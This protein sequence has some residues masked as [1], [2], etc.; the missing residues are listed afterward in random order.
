[1][2]IQKTEKYFIITF[3]YS[4]HLVDAVKN[5]PN[6]MWDNANKCWKV[7]NNYESE[8]MSFSKTYGFRFENT[9]K[10]VVEE[11]IL[12]IPPMP[13]LGHALD[14]QI[15]P[16]PYQKQGIAFGLQ[17]KRF[18]N[19]DK[20]GLGKT[21]QA[22]ATVHTANAYPCL[23]ICPSTLKENWKREFKKF[24]G[25]DRAM[26]LNED[27]KRNYPSFYSAGICNAYITN[28]E[29][30]KKY[31]VDDL[32]NG[33]K[34]LTMKHI[35]FK[36]EIQMFKSIIIDESHRCKNGKAQQTKFCMGISQGK[37]YVI[38]LSGTPVIN[39]PK[40]LIS[41]LHIMGRLG[42][43]GGYKKFV[44][45]YC[46][47]YNGAS[48]LRELNS[49]LA[50]TCF[51]QR[52]K[53]DVLKDLPAKVRQTVICEISTRKEYNDA[54]RDLIRYLRE[55]KNSTDSQIQK[56]MRGEVMVRIGILRQISARGKIKSVCDFVDD[57]IEQGEKVILFVNLHD[58]VNEFK[59]AFPKSVSV[60][61][62]DSHESRQSAVDRF[63]ND[64]SVK[65][66]VC[67]IKAAGVGLTLTSS[68]NVC[69]VEFPWTYADCEQCE[70]RAHRIG[71]KDSVTAYYFLGEK[72]IDEKIYQIIQTKKEI[73][74]AITG[75]T[76]QIEEDVIN[77][78]ANLFN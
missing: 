42:E 47:G 6:R 54:E 9:K 16:Y 67:S 14:L 57:L 8:I 24:T 73:A 55:Y 74:N 44:E 2:L 17:H 32:T 20:P 30:L 75:S 66:I 15:E 3:R 4:P 52:E 36:P 50:N 62:M 63:Q 65:L 11:R 69:F 10:E 28:F 38:L 7:P 41:Q 58:V 45:R 51:F 61:G 64:P 22:I 43:M 27:I 12:P 60:T 1:M 37:E 25:K 21:L 78:I 56:S 68:S 71:Q 5:L 53:K 59:K 23:V 13:E 34:S 39:N 49:V 48:N 46:G 76:E 19:G 26:I 70:D 31:F 33:D 77:M 40:D 35:V 18:L 72:T 29:S